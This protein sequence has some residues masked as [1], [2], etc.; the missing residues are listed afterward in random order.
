[1]GEDFSGTCLLS[2]DLLPDRVTKPDYW[3]YL[4]GTQINYTLTYLAEHS[5]HCNHNTIGRYLTGEKIMP[6]RLSE[7]MQMEICSP[8]SQVV[9]E[10]TVLNK[11]YSALIG[12][13]G[14]Q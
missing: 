12:E 13:M 3:L 2:I 14:R 6:R 11:N 7:A 8:S 5:R 10:D 4:I 1:M 9:L